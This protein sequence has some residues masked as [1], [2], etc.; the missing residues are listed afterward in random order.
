MP[1]HTRTEDQTTIIEVI[2]ELDVATA[3]QLSEYVAQVVKK[4]PEK[5]VLDLSGVKFMASSGLAMLISALKKTKEARVPF[6]ICGLS[7]VVR[8]TIQVT[9]LD[10]VLPIFDSVEDAA[11]NLH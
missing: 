2:G 10:E 3:T 11:K 4:Y 1:Y 9:T 7:P 5:L 6:G 8:Q